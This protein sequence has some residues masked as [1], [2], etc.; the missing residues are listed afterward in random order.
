MG[1]DVSAWDA[2]GKDRKRAS[3]Q[4]PTLGLRNIQDSS[5]WRTYAKFGAAASE[6]LRTFV[7]AGEDGGRRSRL[8]VR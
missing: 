4:A 6:R 8:A 5:V 2:I 3:A 7:L 1:R